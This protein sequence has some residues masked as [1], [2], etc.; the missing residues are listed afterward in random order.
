M[1]VHR[2]TRGA[3]GRREARLD[4]PPASDAVDRRYDPVGRALPAV[5]PAPLSA[6]RPACVPPPLSEPPVQ[7]HFDVVAP[8]EE[9]AEVCVQ[10]LADGT[11]DEEDVLSVD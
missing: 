7:P 2:G 3:R 9:G 10:S 11:R 6:L 5:A 8:I 4:R 1:L